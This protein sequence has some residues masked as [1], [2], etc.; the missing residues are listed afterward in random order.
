MPEGMLA[1][2][3]I[4]FI[5]ID[6][7]IASD[8]ACEV[9]HLVAHL[10]NEYILCETWADRLSHLEGRYAILELPYRLVGKSDFDHRITNFYIVFELGCAPCAGQ[11][12][13]ANPT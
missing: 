1:F 4:P 8:G 2:V 3:G 11:L 6:G 7:C 12:T 9:P 13:T 10:G 5:E